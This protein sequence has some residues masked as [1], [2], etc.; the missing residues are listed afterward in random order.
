ML[1]FKIT[2]P[3]NAVLTG[4]HNLPARSPSTLNT[5]SSTP[6]PIPI[7][8]AL[9][10]GTYT[11][12]YFD[13]DVG[14]T[15]SI[16]SN[17]LGVPIVAINRPGYHD[18][19]SFYPIPEGSSYPEEYGNWLHRHILPAIWSEFGKPSGCDSIVLLSHSLGTTG[20]VIA[21]A[22]HAAEADT[23]RQYPLAGM[24]ISGFGTHPCPSRHSISPTSPA[25][26]TITF[27]PE[28]KDEMMIQK[29]C[30]HPDIY[31]YTEQLNHPMS[32]D[33]IGHVRDV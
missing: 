21:A 2:L 15:A 16:V 8:V 14:H 29:G 7:I 31:Q 5:S 24:I 27:T 18:S 13:V 1:P 6:E 11:A 20:A 10:G 9:H 4:L 32:I 22:M 33:E 30:A 28:F 25:E 23:D 19:T 12:K 26:N 17:G 3:N